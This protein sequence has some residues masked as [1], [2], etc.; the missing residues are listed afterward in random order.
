[1]ADDLN[2][3][4]TSSALRWDPDRRLLTAN[5]T[6]PEDKES[7][8][9]IINTL[10]NLVKEL[11]V[12]TSIPGFMVFI[13]PVKF[14]ALTTIHLSGLNSN[15]TT[16]AMS[17]LAKVSELQELSLDNV[18][19][20][21][22]DNIME[23]LAQ[24]PRLTKLHLSGQSCINRTLNGLRQLTG[25]QSLHLH[26]TNISTAH[27]NLLDE[28]QHL[29]NLA[30]LQ[31]G[32]MPNLA[33]TANNRGCAKSIDLGGLTALRDLRVVGVGVIDTTIMDQLPTAHLTSLVMLTKNPTATPAAAR[34]KK[35]YR[36]RIN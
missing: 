19:C 32:H 33:L 2:T 12:I 28:V 8:Y 23:E 21:K 13:D 22:R 3:A 29:H 16:P 7:L 18:V 31:L 11:H 26:N 14:P 6:A 4:L 34:Q 5:L 15:F 30:S 17:C 35:K 9:D 10:G 1:M 24:L 20:G 27:F 36:Q 25:L